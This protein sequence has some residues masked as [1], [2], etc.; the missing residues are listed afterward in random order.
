[1]CTSEFHIK[2]PDWQGGRAVEPLGEGHI[3]ATIGSDEHSNIRSS[4]FVK[5]NKSVRKD[6]KNGCRQLFRK[7]LSIK[8]TNDIPLV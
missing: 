5:D 2:R 8:A 6:L 1:M 7:F 4:L 3:D